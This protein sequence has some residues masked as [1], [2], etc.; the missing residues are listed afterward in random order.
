MD[1][2]ILL[3][4]LVV[5]LAVF[6]QSL[7]GFGVALVAMA[8]LPS[9]VGI[10][11][12][13]PLVAIVGLVLE[14]VLVI[15]YRQSLDIRAVWKI[16]LAAVVGTPLGVLFLARVNERISLTVL[17]V[18]IAVYALYALLEL[19]LPRLG[20]RGWAYLAGLLGGMLG[21][22]Y[23]TSGPPVIVYA[24]CRRWPPDVFKG[25]LQGYFIIVS[26][27][28][29]VSHAL[30]GNF[31]P[32]IWNMVLWALPFLAIGIIAGL[33]LDRWLNPLTFR[34]VVL[35]LLVLMGIRLMF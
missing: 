6:T 26:S 9:L 33:S 8:L 3:V 12:A 2:T 13:T 11:F 19:K 27:A 34:R 5:F 24:D 32:Q 4:G 31:T 7:S 14:A 35:V 21:G 29:A 22:A 17:G 10:Q 30:N 23:N 20:K 16:A 25:N 18:V 28:I 15:Y 1:M